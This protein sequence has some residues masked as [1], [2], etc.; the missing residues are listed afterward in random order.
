MRS[1]TFL[2]TRTRQACQLGYGQ[3]S[4]IPLAILG[5]DKALTSRKYFEGEPGRRTDNAG[6]NYV[7]CGEPTERQTSS[8]SKATSARPVT[9]IDQSPASK[10]RS[11]RSVLVCADMFPLTALLRGLDPQHSRKMQTGLLRIGNDRE[12]RKSM[13][14]EAFQYVGRYQ[15]IRALP[16]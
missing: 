14:T 1:N 5:K 4:A 2:P 8:V 10:P 13:R 3:D 11:R 7:V 9:S 6:K 16:L 12:E 15:A